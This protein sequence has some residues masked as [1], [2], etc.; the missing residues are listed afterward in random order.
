MGV[1][2]LVIFLQKSVMVSAVTLIVALAQLAEQPVTSVRGWLKVR[3]L[4]AAQSFNVFLCLVFTGVA[5]K[6]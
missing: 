6:L 4:W 1:Y 2:S 5:F 3:I